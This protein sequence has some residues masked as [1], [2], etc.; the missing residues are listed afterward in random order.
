VVA[1]REGALD[2][3]HVHSDTDA[4]SFTSTFPTPGRYRLFLDILIDGQVCIAPFTVD[5]I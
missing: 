2:Y 3:L 1:V 4:L 5:V